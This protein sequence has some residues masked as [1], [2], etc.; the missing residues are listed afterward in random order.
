MSAAPFEVERPPADTA[1]AVPE[2]T[3]AKVASTVDKV[4]DHG[5]RDALRELG[6][7]MA[8]KKRR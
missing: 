5:V 4:E 6:L 8:R 2:V 3:R 7:A 1:P